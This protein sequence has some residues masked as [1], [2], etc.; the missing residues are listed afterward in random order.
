VKYTLIKIPTL[1]NPNHKKECAFVA[2]ISSYPVWKGYEGINKEQQNI[3]IPIAF[4]INRSDGKIGF[5]G[6]IVEENEKIHTAAVRE[7]HEE[8]GVLLSEDELIPFVSFEFDVV[9]HLFLVEKEYNFLFNLFPDMIRAK[10]FGSEITGGLLAQLY[11]YKNQKGITSLLHSSLAPCV[12]EE[13]IEIMIH[14]NQL[15]QIE[16]LPIVKK[17]LLKNG[18]YL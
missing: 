15:N 7:V 8:I 17:Y 3:I 16:H 6:G 11:D 10:H 1:S 18:E 5:P 9:G 2:M 4:M 14:F 12:R 13:L